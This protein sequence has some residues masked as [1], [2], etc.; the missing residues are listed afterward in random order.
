MD[1]TPTGAS[2]KKSVSTSGLYVDRV[3]AEEWTEI[4]NEVWRR[5]RDFFYAPNMHGFDWEALRKQYEPL[6]QYAS[7]R[8]DV[9]YVISE[10]ISELTVQHAYID[11]GDYQIPP[12]PRVALPGARFELDKASN[13]FR[14]ARIFQGQNEEEAYRSPLTEVGVDVKVGDYVLAINGHDL[15]GKD[16]PYRLLRNAAD[17]PVELAGQLHAS[18]E[19]A[20][21]VTLPADHQRSQ[22]GL[23]RLGDE[24]PQAG[25]TSSRAAASATSTCPTWAPTASASS[26]SGTTRSSARKP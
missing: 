9:N 10:M 25:W 22:A 2:G 23:F 12:R 3:P 7:H 8:T 5:Y 4:F 16:D 11:G 17:N 13:R 6:L 19:G 1:A 20:R 18:T 26:S 15:T 21:T 24:Q 14:I